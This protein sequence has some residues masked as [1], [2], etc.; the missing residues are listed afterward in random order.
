MELDDM[1]DDE[2][3]MQ[4]FRAIPLTANT[5]NTNELK[6]CPFC[7]GDK[8]LEIVTVS[9]LFGDLDLHP[10]DYDGVAVICT[11]CGATSGFREI[12]EEAFS[13]WNTRTDPPEVTHQ[14]V[15]SF[16]EFVDKTTDL[17]HPDVPYYGTKKGDS[18]KKWRRRLVKAALTLVL[19]PN[20]KL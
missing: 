19:T 1:W 18:E 9:E 20:A 14:M 4:S 5:T 6:P 7:G 3:D 8:A 10:S 13:N 15:D 2:E 16:L 12:E 17:Y 11:A